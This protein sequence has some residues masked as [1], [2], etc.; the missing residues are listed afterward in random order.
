MMVLTLLL[1]HLILQLRQKKAGF[2][3]DLFR[4]PAA[5]RDCRTQKDGDGKSKWIV[6]AL[7]WAL[8]FL[9]MNP[10]TI[11]LA[12]VLLLLMFA[13]G[14][15]N[16]L[17][18][19]AFL[20]ACAKNRKKVDAGQKPEPDSRKDRL[21][22]FY[23]SMGLAIYGLVS[24]LL[25]FAVDYHWWVRLAVTVLMVL[26]ALLQVFLPGVFSGKLRSG[27]AVIFLLCLTAMCAAAIFG[28]SLGIVLAD[29]GGWSESGGT[30]AG[31]MQNAG[32]GIILGISLLTIGLALGWSLGL[33]G[34]LSLAAGAGTFVVGLTDTKSGDYVRKSARQYFFG[35]EDGENKTIFCTGA[36][37]LNFAA[38]FGSG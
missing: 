12:A 10:I 22:L 14:S 13:Q 19:T 30:L 35:A 32:F 38:G 9:V 4:I 2:F 29:D 16:L 37:L 18:Q 1:R 8:G 31:L 26:F 15:G 27:T 5:V 34:A 7:V 33:V 20:W 17:V 23:G 21:L 36:E 6:L 3:A 24:V 28:S 11:I 25:W